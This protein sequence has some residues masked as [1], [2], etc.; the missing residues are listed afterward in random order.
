MEGE[1]VTLKLYGNNKKI[2]AIERIMT[3]LSFPNGFK[4]VMPYCLN[5]I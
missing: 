1:N 4:D 5:D 3:R 2:I